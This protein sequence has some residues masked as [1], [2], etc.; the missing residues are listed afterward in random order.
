MEFAGDFIDPFFVCVAIACATLILLDWAIGKDRR[1]ALKTTMAEWWVYLDDRGYIGLAQDDVKKARGLLVL[2]QD[3]SSNLVS[4]RARF[5]CHLILAIPGIPL[6]FLSIW[7]LYFGL[8]QERFFPYASPLLAAVYTLA[9][10]YVYSASLFITVWLL[11]II[12]KNST[13]LT[14]VFVVLF[15]FLVALA[16]LTISWYCVNV[17]EI[18]VS[19]VEEYVDLFSLPIDPVSIYERSTTVDY[20]AFTASSSPTLLHIGFSAAVL[21]SKLFSFWLKPLVMFLI[22][23]FEESDRGVLTQL[24]ILLAVVAKAIQEAIKAFGS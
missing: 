6:L 3:H 11:G 5:F 24:S 14:L 20:L 7:H 8:E 13:V 4:K 1:E 15:D 10:W 18:L 19:P 12:V 17:A 23:R 22:Y 16:I 21:L 2:A 9:L